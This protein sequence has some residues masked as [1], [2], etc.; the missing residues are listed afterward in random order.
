MR[1]SRGDSREA[2]RLY[3][4]AGFKHHNAY[5]AGDGETLMLAMEKSHA[6][7]P[8]KIFDIQR[9]LED[10]DLVAVHSK[11]QQTANDIEIAVMHIL[12]F[13]SLTKIIELWDFGQ[14]TP[15]DMVNENGMF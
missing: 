14:R 4:G 5:F 6:N 7:N 10:G 12:Q 8:N 15:E 3:V 11:V 2:F 1:C 9:A 13:N